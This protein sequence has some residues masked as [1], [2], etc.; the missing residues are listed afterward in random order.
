MG[1]RCRH[2]P[3]AR[4]HPRAHRHRDERTADLA[5]RHAR[6]SARAR[7]SASPR[8]PQTDGWMSAGFFCSRESSSTTWAARLHLEGAA[9][10]TGSRR[11]AHG[12]P[13]DG[14]FSPW[15]PIATYQHLNDLWNRKAAPWKLWDDAPARLRAWWQPVSA[16]T[17][18]DTG[19]TAGAGT[20]ATGWW[21]R[22]YRRLWEAGADVVCLVRDWV[23][24]SELVAPVGA[25]QVK[26]VRGDVCDRAPSN[27]LGEYEIDT[28]FS[29]RRPNHRGNRQ[30]QSVS[31]FESNIQALELLEACAARRPSASSWRPLPIRLWRAGTTPYSENAPLAGR[32]PYDASNPAPT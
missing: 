3:P 23:P 18:T 7:W 27:A 8:K 19:G 16:M 30:P 26:V 31:T 2:Q 21:A 10:A 32:H 25:R 17:T 9:R 5:V 6:L 15:T 4:F 1:E 29:P 20:G 22:G 28:V 14:F 24:Q 13:A 11:A 12:L